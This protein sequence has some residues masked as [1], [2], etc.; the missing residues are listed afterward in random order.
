MAF[1][2]SKEAKAVAIARRLAR[3]GKVESR[4]QAIARDDR[5]KPAK[6]SRKG[7]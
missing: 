6:H 5:D 4:L 7:Y 3:K 1:D 2:R